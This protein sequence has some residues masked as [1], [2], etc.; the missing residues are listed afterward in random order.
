MPSGKASG[1]CYKGK[2]TGFRKIHPSFSFDLPLP[3]P[4]LRPRLLLLLCCGSLLRAVFGNPD[5]SLPTRR[6]ADYVDR[7]Y[8]RQ[9]QLCDCSGPLVMELGACRIVRLLERM[10]RGNFSQMEFLSLCLPSRVRV[11]SLGRLCFFGRM[12]VSGTKVS[13]PDG[14]SSRVWML[15][16]VYMTSGHVGNFFMVA[17]SPG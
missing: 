6:N 5:F 7:R 4:P 16:L 1:H 13:I 3:L 12:L 2:L 9:T 8:R 15:L 17:S 11:C 14:A 10:G